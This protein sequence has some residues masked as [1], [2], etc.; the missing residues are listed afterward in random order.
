MSSRLLLHFYLI[1]SDTD[2]TE[3]FELACGR[4]VTSNNKVRLFFVPTNVFS[5]SS[6]RQNNVCLAKCSIYIFITLLTTSPRPL[7][8]YLILPG[9][10]TNIL[11]KV[12]SKSAFYDEFGRKLLKEKRKIIP[13]YIFLFFSLKKSIIIIIRIHF[14]SGTNHSFLYFCQMKLNNYIP[15]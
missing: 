8:T 4:H 2:R 14:V 7:T 15:K 12:H 10:G 5:D 9:E 11:L 1:I 3:R 6:L 13:V